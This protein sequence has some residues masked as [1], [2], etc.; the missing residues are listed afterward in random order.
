MNFPRASG[1]LLHPTSFPGSYG[2]GDLGRRR[3][4]LQIFLF[5]RG[6][7][8]WQVLPL[9]TNRLRRFSLRVLFG[10]CG[11]HVSR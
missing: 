4:S 5:Q 7:V 8:L 10:F 2:I 1:I 6:K 9:G 11:Q 3:T